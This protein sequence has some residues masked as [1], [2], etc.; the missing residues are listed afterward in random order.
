MTARSLAIAEIDRDAWNG[1]SRSLKV[2]R[3]A[4]RRGVYNFRLAVNINLTPIFNRSS[5]NHA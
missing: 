2:I 3:C 4:N 1:H 5:G